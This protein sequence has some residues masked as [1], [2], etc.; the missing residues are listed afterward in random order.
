MVNLKILIAVV[1]F[2]III[3]VVTGKM[4]FDGPLTSFPI[5]RALFLNAK[6]MYSVVDGYSVYIKGLPMNATPALLEKEF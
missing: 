6:C 1:M 2:L 4:P 3:F 5:E